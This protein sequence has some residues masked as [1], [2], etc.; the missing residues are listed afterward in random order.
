MS[1]QTGTA[2]NTIDLLQK[3]GTW[4]AS[5]GWT[6]D[7][8]IVRGTGWRLHCHKA[9]LYMNFSAGFNEGGTVA[10]F[11]NSYGSLN[12]YLLALYAGDGYSSGSDW[13]SQSGG[14]ILTGTANKCGCG[15]PMPSGAIVAYH[16]FADSAGDNCVVVIERTAGIFSHMFWGP[17]LNK[18]GS[19]TGG[20]YFGASLDNYLLGFPVGG[21]YG[22]PGLEVST[23]PP[24][25]SKDRAEM[26]VRADVD[27][28]LNKWVSI[29][30]T[31]TA[32]A[33]STGKPGGS[34]ISTED[35]T[36]HGLDIAAMV[37]RGTSNLTAQSLLFPIVVGAERDSAGHSLL[38]SIPNIFITNACKK[39]FAA[40]GEYLWGGDTYKIFPGSTYN[41]VTQHYG[42]AIKKV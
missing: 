17:S 32:N 35:A 36:D 12:D 5:T 41:A 40:G 34:N 1:Y 25:L 27:T 23:Y 33:G 4:L 8:S 2:S 39:G 13:R 38:G 42:F 10:G 20:P 31:N 24:G 30:Q 21:G 19:W 22:T 6:I 16:F 18:I 37:E 3:I 9:A 28:W 11:I 26:Y 7:S 14:P 15:C 29:C